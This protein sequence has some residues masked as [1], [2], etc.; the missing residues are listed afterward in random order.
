MKNLN[1]H[2]P[3]TTTSNMIN[4]RQPNMAYPQNSQFCYGS[5]SLTSSTCHF[6][7][8]C[9]YNMYSLSVYSA[10]TYHGTK[11]RIVLP[12]QERPE[13]LE[14]IKKAGGQIVYRDGLRVH[15]I[16]NMSRSLVFLH[17]KGNGTGNGDGVLSQRTY[18][19]PHL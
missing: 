4:M 18:H 13:E 8:A 11:W 2:I 17:K 6:M 7:Q 5:W 9:N 14:R 3:S 19:I 10:T 16:L 12:K 1:T 15:G